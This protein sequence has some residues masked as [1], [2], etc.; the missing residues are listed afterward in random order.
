[1]PKS[2]PPLSNAAPS[3]A[4]PFWHLVLV[5]SLKFLCQLNLATRMLMRQAPTAAMT[6]A[7]VVAVI[8]SRR[9]PTRGRFI[10]AAFCY[11]NHAS[12]LMLVLVYC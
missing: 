3:S 12:R 1:M 11:T 8:P 9:H 2:A 5:H 4:R 7:E 6:Q 10:D